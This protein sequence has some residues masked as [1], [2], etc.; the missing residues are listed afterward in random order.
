MTEFLQSIKLD[1]LSRR[2]LPFVALA[3]VVLVVAVA[4]AAAGGSD[5]SAVTSSAGAASPHAPTGAIA[6][7]LAP[8]NPT[9]AVSETPAGTRYQSQGPTRDPFIPLPTPPAAKSASTGGSSSA[10]ASKSAG[11][12]GSGSSGSSS[13]GSGG[14]SHSSPAPN[15]AKPAKPAKPVN[16]YVVSVLFGL[17]PATPGQSVTLTPYENL[18]PQ[19]PLPSIQNARISFERVTSDGKGGVFKLLVPPILRGSGVCLPSALE[20]QTIDVEV[21]H[22][23]ELEYVEAGGSVAIYELKM[24]SIAKSTALAAR[25]KAS[26]KAA[27]AKKHKP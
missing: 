9:E 20:C 13:G 17:L 24:V 26:A 8:A 5:G 7:A 6:V 18:K 14:G 3:V 10:S 23:E 19:Q 27:L 15:P 2:L 21:G 25:A 11:K 12:S 16:P 22:A 4:Y 1:L